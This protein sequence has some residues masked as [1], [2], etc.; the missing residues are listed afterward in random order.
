MEQLFVYGS[1]GPG[2]ANQ[3]ILAPLG[4]TWQQA[5][6]RGYLRQEGW[7]AAM[8]FPGLMLDETGDEVSGYLY[9]SDRLAEFWPQLDEFEGGQYKRVR[10][11]ARLADGS[12]VEAFVYVLSGRESP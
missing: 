10:T 9:T 4:G 6:L 5:S 8:G 3:H 12:L 11:S 7:G 1:L 2:R